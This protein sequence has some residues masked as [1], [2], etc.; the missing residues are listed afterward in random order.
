MMEMKTHMKTGLLAVTMALALGGIATAQGDGRMPPPPPGGGMDQGGGPMVFGKVKAVDQSAKTIKLSGSRGGHW[1][2]VHVA[3]GA[4]IRAEIQVS[5]SDLKVGDEI[6]VRGVP[7]GITA[8]S[9]MDGDVREALPPPPGGPDEMGGPDQDGPQ[10]NGP[11]RRS[12]PPTMANASGKITSTSPLTIE[13]SK[14]VSVVIKTSASVKVH[15]IVAEQ[16]SDI[17]VGD[18]IIASGDPGDDGVLDADHVAINVH[19]P[20]PPPGMGGPGMGGPG[21]GGPGRRGGRG[22]VGGPQMGDGGGPDGFDGAG[23][24]RQGP[25]RGFGGGPQGGPGGPGGDGYCGGGRQ[26]GQRPPFGG[27]DD[28]GPGGG[29]GFGGQGRPDGPPP[30]DM[31]DDQPSA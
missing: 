21:F 3:D 24:G 6:A 25:G 16:L 14:D 2:V 28:Q 8:T 31:G 30:P 19:M 4:T 11:G 12:G 5:A 23:G 1:R 18:R 15:K 20:P 26:F 13:I 9:I 29:P 10:G 22:G 17:K 27:P 7:T